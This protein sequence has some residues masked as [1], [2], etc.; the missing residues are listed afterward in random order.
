VPA[1]NF[2]SLFSKGWNKL[3]GKK[4]DLNKLRTQSLFRAKKG[5]MNVGTPHDWEDY[6]KYIDKDISDN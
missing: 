3:F 6:K 4:E 1:K 2:R 5:I